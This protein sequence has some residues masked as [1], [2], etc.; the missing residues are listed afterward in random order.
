[1]YYPE[2]CLLHVGAPVCHVLPKDVPFTCWSTSFHS[3]LYISANLHS[4]INQYTC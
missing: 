3:L 1:M 4:M 2:M